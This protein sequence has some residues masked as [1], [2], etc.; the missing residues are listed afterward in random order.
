MGKKC[1]NALKNRY[2]IFSFSF[3]LYA[4]YIAYSI[5]Y[6]GFPVRPLTSYAPHPS[7]NIYIYIYRYSITPN[8]YHRILLFVIHTKTISGPRGTIEF[9]HFT[10][11]DRLLKQKPPYIRLIRDPR[12]FRFPL[13]CNVADQDQRPNYYNEVVYDKWLKR[14]I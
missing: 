10:A 6:T 13:C 1:E 12:F 2:F 7:A 3:V 11:W 8:Y 9:C 5:S 14:L 4:A